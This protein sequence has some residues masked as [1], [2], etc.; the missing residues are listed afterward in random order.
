MEEVE[1]ETAH[2]AFVPGCPEFGVSDALPASSARFLQLQSNWDG[3]WHPTPVEQF[4][5]VLSGGFEIRTTDGQSRNFRRGDIV[6]LADT[7]GKGH[8]TTIA[9]GDE[10]WILA[11][12][13][14]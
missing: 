9:D 3:G 5:T 4:L 1:I 8:H 12:A 13:L 14:G 2:A 6:R 11:V 7:T 10:T